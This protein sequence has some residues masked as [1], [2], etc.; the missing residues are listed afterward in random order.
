MQNI[1]LRSLAIGASVALFAPGLAS[2][3]S[4]APVTEVNGAEDEIIVTAQKRAQRLQDV[5]LTI[6]VLTGEQLDRQSITNIQD[7]QNTTPELNF[8][9]QPS[10][11][12]SIRGSG[13]QTFTRSAENNVLIVV[14]GV[15]LGQLTPPTSS[16]FDLAQIEVLSGPQG[17]LFG[18]NASAGVVNI[19]TQAPDPSDASAF[20]RL[21]AGEE[22]YGV[23]NMMANLPLSD[24]AALRLTAS[25]DQRDGTTFNRFNSQTIDDFANDAFRAR[26]LWEVTPNFSLNVIAD[27]ESQQGGNTVW[28]ARIAPNIGPTSIGGRL[29]ACGVTPGPENTEVCLDG[30]AFREVEGK[31]LSVQAGWDIGGVT[32]TSISAYRAYTREVDTDSDTRPINAL[33]R[34]L[35]TDDISQ[36]TQEL[37]IANNGDGRFSYVAGAFWYDYNYDSYTEQAGTLGLLPFVA[38]RSNTDNVL[39]QSVAVFGQAEFD[40]T[41]KITL[42]AGGRQTWEKVKLGA[43]S[44]V[45]PGTGVR[46]APA[47]SPSVDAQE[48]RAETTDNFSYRLGAQYMPGRDLTFFATYSKGYKGPA[49]NTTLGGAF[50]PGIVRPEVPT[51]I[52]VGLK[53]VA[54]DG[55]V[56]TD[57]SFFDTTVED[58][59]AQTAIVAG[60]LTRFVFSNASELNF[61]GAQ[62]N[63]SAEP[64]DNLNLNFGALYNEA[65]YGDFIVQCN[66]PFTAGCTP[67]AGGSLVTNANGRQLAGAPEWKLTLGG[68][69]EFPMGGNVLGFVDANGAYRSETTTSAT[70]DPNL[71]IPSYTLVDA[72]L[73]LRADN[74]A[75]RI[76]LFGK[77]IFDERA[78]GFIFRDPLSPTGNYMQS[79][80]SNAFRTVGVT[81]E[82]NF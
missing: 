36:W 49:V 76:A 41:D 65:T 20:V 54:F 27:A 16:L 53:S 55:R 67:A 26:L 61:H 11:G 43:A 77:N 2:A 18:K 42:I 68:S 37:R 71:V 30:P 40:L 58:F 24:T 39:Q 5:P 38:A 64:I 25:R 72:R 57:L 81:V 66:A 10:S 44:F 3:Q 59:Q 13:T 50:A 78:A 62:L 12:Y 52:E 15:V 60:G 6:S 17:M 47:F 51:N 63:L 4:P 45:R 75:W 23:F 7:V 82:L 19:T 48:I 29:A 8:V 1:L 21:S 69:Y 35:A 34:N 33:N 46:F 70:P 80:A 28:T 22:G 32:L 14:D 74:G 31:G 56:R 79:F 9:G 73:G